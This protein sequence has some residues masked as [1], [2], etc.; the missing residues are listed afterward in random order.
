MHVKINSL[1]PKIST[2]FKLKSYNSKVQQLDT[3]LIRVRNKLINKLDFRKLNRRNQSDQFIKIGNYQL[4][5]PHDYP[6][7]HLQLEVFR[8]QL[9]IS[10]SKYAFNDHKNKF[11]DAGAN[12]GLTTAIIKSFAPIETFGV[13]IEPSE[14][15]LT[16]LEKNSENFFPRQ[17]IPKYL[18]LNYPIENLY[19]TLFHWGGTAHLVQDNNHI[20]TKEQQID[21]HTLI[22]E[23]TAL[24]KLD[25][26]Y[27]DLSI[28]HHVLPRLENITP[29]IIFEC[30]IRNQ[31]DFRKIKEIFT[32]LKNKGYKYF[33]LM[34]NE[35]YLIY[36]GEFNYNLMNIIF[37]QLNIRKH[38]KESLF[39]YSDVLVFP[40]H[41][42]DIY[43][44]VHADLVQNQHEI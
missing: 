6:L 24:V 36:S 43:E 8:E 9:L 23:R 4:I 37:Y 39:Y 26:D 15:Y 2:R 20:I 13:L 17:I 38:G 33:I 12:V 44:L 30:V 19:L 34:H 35:G 3:Y 25:V 7:E 27:S 32:N 1:L 14:K 29:L 16:Y 41:S 11:I 40:E 18:S 21:L 22:D 42:K 5:L 28:L 10:I 31:D